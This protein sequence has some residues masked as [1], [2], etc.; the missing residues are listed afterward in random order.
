MNQKRVRDMKQIDIK[1]K[2]VMLDPSLLCVNGFWK[3]ADSLRDFFPEVYV[4]QGIRQM[5]NR[6]LR[7]FY[8]GYLSQK[9]MLLASDMIERSRMY[10]SFSWTEYQNKIPEEFQTR[11]GSLREYLK[12]SNLPSTVQDALLDEFFFLIIHSSILS[13]LKKTFKTFEK[14]NALPLLN[15][16]KIAPDEWKESVRGLKKAV[17]VVRW[18]ASIGAFS[19]WLGPYAGPISGTVV[20]QGIRLLLVDP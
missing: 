16:E 12:E 13:R 8:G 6:E 10:K 20:D 3:K 17:D 2:P 5:E 11:V 1:L 9:R 4:P 18:I 7:D 14:C 15:L 19:V